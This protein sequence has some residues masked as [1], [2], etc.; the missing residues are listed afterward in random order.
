[1]DTKA[2]VN[3]GEYSRHGRSRSI[4]PVGAW[5]HDMNVKEKL[6]PSGILEVVSGRSFLSF[7]A[8][9]NT[10]DFLADG[11]QAW[12]RERQSAF[13]HVK[14]LV[15]NTDN[16]PE[17][18]GRRTRFLQ[19]AVQ[20]ADETGLELHLVYY[21][22]YH[23]K[24]NAIERFWGGLERSWN[25]YLL[26]NI[27]TVINRASNFAWKGIKAAVTLF[28]GTYKKGVK[29]T[30]KAKASVEERLHRSLKLPWWDIIIKPK[31]GILVNS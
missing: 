25:G 6:V 27:N 9:N 8:S 10:S 17:C 3:V 22:P 19:R 28:D 23:S 1:M 20:F 14:R 7:T 16:G 30:G 18:S 5:D 31:N 24:Y 21:P 29:L 11:L 2:I 12:W 15:I 13:P 4:K 26:N